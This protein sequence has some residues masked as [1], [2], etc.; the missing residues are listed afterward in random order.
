[1]KLI[2]IGENVFRSIYTS[3]ITFRCG[4]EEIDFA[5]VRN[6]ILQNDKIF[7][8]QFYYSGP[9][10]SGQSPYGRRRWRGRRR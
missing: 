7:N 10:W 6:C 5:K 3:V 2:F 8:Q 9:P 1:M 4:S